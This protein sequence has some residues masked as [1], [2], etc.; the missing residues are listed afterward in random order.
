M[1]HTKEHPRSHK[2]L[3]GHLMALGL[4]PWHPHLLA[5]PFLK[6]NSQHVLAVLFSAGFH[7]HFSPKVL[8]FSVSLV[9]KN[10]LWRDE[11]S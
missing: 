4:N 6:N 10:Q 5:F 3:Q 7:S 8:L 11:P 1:C 2:D 9:H